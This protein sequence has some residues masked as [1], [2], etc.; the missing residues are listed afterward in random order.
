M[1]FETSS[2][3]LFVCCCCIATTSSRWLMLSCILRPSITP[4]KIFR[5]RRLIGFKHNT[6][7]SDDFSY[8]NCSR[9]HII[10]QVLIMNLI[11]I[12]IC[13]L[14]RLLG[15]RA[16]G[17]IAGLFVLHSPLGSQSAEHIPETPHPQIAATSGSSSQ[18][19]SFR[20]S[21]K[22]WR[23]LT[24]FIISTIYSALIWGDSKFGRR[25]ASGWGAGGRAKRSVSS[26]G[27]LVSPALPMF[28]TL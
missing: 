27:G 13:V 5:T 15:C 28:H 26:L 4:R 8:L 12:L 2:G 22:L 21:T 6:E 11:R 7:L 3:A 18:P 24:Q 19:Q 25:P 23:P 10:D 20:S 14:S 9:Q 16:W 1:K 17:C